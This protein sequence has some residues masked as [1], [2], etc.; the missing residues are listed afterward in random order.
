MLCE[1]DNAEQARAVM[2][3]RA[4]S[5]AGCSVLLIHHAGAAGERSRG[6]TELEGFAD[7]LVHLQLAEPQKPDSRA[8]TLLVRGRLTGS[9]T[10]LRMELNQDGL[11]YQMIEGTLKPVRSDLWAVMEALV[12]PEPP[13][14]TLADFRASWPADKPCPSPDHLRVMVSRY[15]PKCGWRKTDAPSAAVLETDRN[16]G[17]A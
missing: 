12:P 6:G 11:D 9:P 1:N 5:A 15:G 7:Q 17:T 14:W 16:S 10:K 3:T 8:R 4:L 13:G 2:P